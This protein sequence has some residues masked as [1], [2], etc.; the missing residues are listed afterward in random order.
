MVTNSW[1]Y[2]TFIIGGASSGKT[3]S[4][5]NLLSQQPNI[6]KIYLCAK[7]PFEPKYQFLINKQESTGLKH[8]T[9][10]KAFIEY[11]DDMNNI[12]ENIKQSNPN[13]KRKILIVFNDMT[14]D[15][16]NTKKLYPVVTELFIRGRKLNIS[17]I[18]LH[19]LI[20]LYQNI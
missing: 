11:S 9:D 13:K 3:N 17:L 12:H 20:L 6:D 19:N 16:L 5:F 4:L 8:I 2:R 1:L 7:D 10:S 15:M 14:A 18:L